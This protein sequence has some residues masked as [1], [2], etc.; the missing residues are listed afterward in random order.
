MQVK[1]LCRS[2][3]V[4][5]FQSCYF[6]VYFIFSNSTCIVKFPP[7]V[8]VANPS[9]IGKRVYH[10][11]IHLESILNEVKELENKESTI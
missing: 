7:Q 6:S 11:F 5:W 10:S 3:G 8:K 9:F 4:Y 1:R 2:E